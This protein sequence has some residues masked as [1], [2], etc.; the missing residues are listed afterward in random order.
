M[1]SQFPIPCMVKDLW[2]GLFELAMSP[3][4][5]SIGQNMLGGPKLLPLG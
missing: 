1:M 2:L 4:S 5:A 3:K